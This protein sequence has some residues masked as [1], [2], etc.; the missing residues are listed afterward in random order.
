M[1]YPRRLLLRFY[2]GAYEE[3]QHPQNKTQ[4]E[5]PYLERLS[6]LSEE[7]TCQRRCKQDFEKI[8]CNPG[9]QISA[10]ICPERISHLKTSITLSS[11][12]EATIIWVPLKQG[13]PWQ[14]SRSAEIYSSIFIEPSRCFKNSI[15]GRVFKDGV[16]VIISRRKPVKTT[17][18]APALVLINSHKYLVEDL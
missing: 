11:K 15:S 16:R 2:P 9:N 4:Y 12:I 1:Q 18:K 14:M 17:G 13:F 6:K 3:S 10:V 8:P 5:Q 7:L